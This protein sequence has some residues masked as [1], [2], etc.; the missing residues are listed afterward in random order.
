MHVIKKSRHL[1]SK[2]GAIIYLF[3]SISKLYFHHKSFYWQVFTTVYMISNSVAFNEMHD[4]SIFLAFIT[5]PH[6][7]YLF[8]SEWI[9]LLLRILWRYYFPAVRQILNSTHCNCEHIIYYIWPKI[10]KHLF[11]NLNKVSIN[12]FFFL[13][14][15]K[16]RSRPLWF[17]QMQ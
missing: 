1:N 3:I 2:E 8:N 13:Y 10:S 7:S 12:L 15:L 17:N 6:A 16:T 5:C 14:F 9:S 4:L 11:L